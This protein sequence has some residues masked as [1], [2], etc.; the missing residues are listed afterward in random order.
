MSRIVRKP[1]YLLHKPTGQ[2]RVRVGGKDVYLGAHGSPESRARYDELVSDW[3]T[4]NGDA[5]AFTLTVDEFC[6]LYLE[7]ARQHYRKGGNVTSEYGGVRQ[8]LRYLV[9]LCGSSRAREFGPRMLKQVRDEMIQAEHVRTSINQHIGR[10]RRMFK[11]GVGEEL[12]P[13]TVLVG[14]QAVSGLREGRTPAKE[15]DPVLPVSQHFIDAME[16]YVSRQ[17][18]AMVQLQILTGARSG[19]LLPIRGADINMQGA[20]WEFVPRSHKTQHHGKRR[21]IFLGP[22][23]QA[24]VREFLKADLQ[25]PLFSPADALA[26]HRA[27]LRAARQTPLTPSQRLRKPKLNPTKQPREMYDVVSYHHA[28]AKACEKAFDMPPELRDIRDTVAR[29]PESERDAAKKRL[30]AEASAWRKEWSW[31]PHQLR[32]N[33]ATELRREFGLEAAQVVLGHASANITQV[34]AE[35]DSE[36]ARLIMQQVG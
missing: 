15:S 10:I 4:R 5:R 19:E 7:H 31:H 22:K 33:A 28:I 12:I 2:A 29:L 35:R 13:P 32:H 25:A 24:I 3:F 36:K 30:Q 17:V 11:W 18:W 8:A 26:E 6:L 16:P 34:Y 9:K 1:T 23:A 21:I 20:V 27:E 14:L